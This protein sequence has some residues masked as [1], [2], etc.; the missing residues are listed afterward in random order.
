MVDVGG[1]G[2]DGCYGGSCYR[3][4]WWLVAVSVA[5]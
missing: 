2:G 4:C 5:C 1:G 3:R